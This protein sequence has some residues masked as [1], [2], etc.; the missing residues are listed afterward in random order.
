MINRKGRTVLT[1]LHRTGPPAV[2][3]DDDVGAG[4]PVKGAS[5]GFALKLQVLR[6]WRRPLI[7]GIAYDAPRV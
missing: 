1:R 6:Y 5:K 3:S 7:C 4:A 2:D